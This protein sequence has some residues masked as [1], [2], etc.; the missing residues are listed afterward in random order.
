MMKS[1]A[2]RGEGFTYLIDDVIRTNLVE[3]IELNL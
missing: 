3:W 2:L 1:E